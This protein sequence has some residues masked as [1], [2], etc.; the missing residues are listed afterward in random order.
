MRMLDKFKVLTYNIGIVYKPLANLIENGLEQG[1]IRWLKHNESNCFFADPFLVKEENGMLYMLCEELSFWDN[2]GKISLIIIDKANFELHS[3]KVLIE[4]P[5][6][7]SFPYL[8]QG[9]YILPESHKGGKAYLYH[10]NTAK[11]EIDEKREICDECGFVDPIVFKIGNDNQILLS[12]DNLSER[13]YSFCLGQDGKYH[14]TQEKAVLVDKAR[15]RSAG[16][17]FTYNGHL[18]RPVQDCVERYGRQ[19]RIVKIK[20]MSPSE[21]ESED[22]AVITGDKNP[23]YNETLHTFNVYDNYVIVDGSKD[24][25]RFPIK[26]LFKFSNAIKR[27]IH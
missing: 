6:H 5:W 7:L 18:L 1:D 22:I 2:K 8:I 24:I 13:L 20:K 19:T 11:W 4:E 12:T 16:C 17:P 27:R 25:I 14:K 9:E 23:P 3:K 26:I 15:S 21:Y 10:L